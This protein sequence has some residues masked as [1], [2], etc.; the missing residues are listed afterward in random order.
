MKLEIAKLSE[1]GG[2]KI[3]E[4]ACDYWSDSSLT[5]CVL[6]DGVGGYA[7]GDVA[8]RMVIEHA[9]E[10]FARQPDCSSKVIELLFRKVDEALTREQQHNMTLAKMRATGVILIIDSVNCKAAWGH[11]GDSRLYCFRSGSVVLRTRDHSIAQNMIDT[12]YL[13][14]SEFRS[15]PVRNQLYAALGNSNLAELDLLQEP[16]SVQCGD[17]FLMCSDGL[18]QYVDDHE[19]VS[20]IDSVSSATEWLTNLEKLVLTRGDSTQDNYSAIAVWCR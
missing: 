9:C 11:I 16:I 3:N 13:K 4:D 6:S 18:W 17:T 12:G 15:S 14:P 8:S 20:M 19:M 5:C 10:L 7:G 1:A 2:R